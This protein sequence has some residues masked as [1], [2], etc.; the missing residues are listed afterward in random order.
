[1]INRILIRIKIIQI[2]YSFYKSDGKSL[3][4]AEK[5][6]FHSIEKTYDLYYHLLQ[7]AVEITHYANLRTDARKNKLRPTPEDLNPNMRFV[8][9]RYIKQLASNKLT[10]IFPNTAYHGQIIPKSLKN[11]TTIL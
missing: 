10:N 6:L 9:N 8:E 1:M 2:L 7:L 11:F 3:P 5:E 4:S